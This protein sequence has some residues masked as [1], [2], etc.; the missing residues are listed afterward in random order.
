MSPSRIEKYA[1]LGDTETAALVGKDGSIDWLCT[2]RF[3]SAACFA[4][5]LGKPSNGRW[6]IS[7]QAPVVRSHRAYRHDTLV[8]ESEFETA[9]GRVALID[10]MPPRGRTS[11]LVRLVEG[12]TGRVA[13]RME[14]ILRFDYGAVVPWVSRLADGALQAVAGPDLTVL[15]TPAPLRG[16]GLTTVSDF[17]VAAGETVPFVLSYGPAWQPPPEPVDPRV[18]LERTETFWRGWRAEGGEV[19]GPYAGTVGRSLITLKALTHAPTGGIVAAP[20]TS[21]RSS[22]E[23]AAIGTTATAGSATP[24]GS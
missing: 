5:L 10:F 8:L 14:L 11:D 6:L 18:A 15:R 2:P 22:P 3:D 19:G 20:T 13:M 9:G 12:R 16:E 21:C 1:M 17:D 24:P 7:P 4:A 23:A